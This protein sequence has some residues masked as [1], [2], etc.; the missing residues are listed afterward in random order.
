MLIAALPYPFC[1][2]FET[3]NRLVLTRRKN[4][5]SME[6]GAF[7]VCSACGEK[8]RMNATNCRF[9]GEHFQYTS[10][11]TVAHSE[12]LAC[13][14]VEGVVLDET[15][16]QPREPRRSRNYL[17]KHWRGELP[18]GIS[19]LANGVFLTFL[20]AAGLCL[21]TPIYDD[22]KLTGVSAFGIFLYVASLGF[23][24]WQIAGGWRS[25][26]IH[27]Q[28][29]GKQRWAT[30]AKG[31][32]LLGVFC[33]G[34]VAICTMIPQICEY[35]IGL[36]GDRKLPHYQIRVLPGEAEIEFNGGLHAGAAKH[37][38]QILEV[39]PDVR[40]L[41]L[42]SD[43]GRMHEATEMARLVSKRKLATCVH[44][45]CLGTST[46]VFL[47]GNERAVEVNARL[48]FCRVDLAAITG[49]RRDKLNQM[50]LEIFREADV[51][52]EFANR[53]LTTPRD[54]MWIPSKDDMRVAGVITSG[55]S[56]HALAT[57]AEPQPSRSNENGQTWLS[58]PLVKKLRS[59]EPAL[60]MQ[61]VDEVFLAIKQGKTKSETVQ[62]V[63][64]LVEPIAMNY[65]STTNRQTNPVL[66]DYWTNLLA[67]LSEGNPSL[68]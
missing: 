44:E 6:E 15:G 31:F 4:K 21:T 22:P 7:K 42:N 63:R 19:C 38:E 5:N 43:G 10:L 24:V 61:L 9:C 30:L 11:Q 29:G 41:H 52:K 46:L 45:K 32:L 1:D 14:E 47:S 39:M 33:V 66:R 56:G 23:F 67:F 62:G 17:V 35:A 2:E 28:Q 50:A 37:L 49:A 60:Y 57:G 25:A 20:T 51:S 8:I 68:Q 53:A 26:S 54:Q 55:C 64:A 40:I 16:L 18:L 58:L 13:I 36:A 3:S 27:V 65:L 12:S 59:L 34:R 48:G